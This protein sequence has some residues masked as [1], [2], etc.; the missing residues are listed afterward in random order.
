MTAAAIAII[1]AIAVYFLAMLLLP[2]RFFAD[3]G[4]YLQAS[5]DRLAR[6]Q[7]HVMHK[8]AGEN[9]SEAEKTLRNPLVRAYLLLPGARSTLPAL[10]RANLSDKIDKFVMYGVV[11]LIGLFFLTS[12][13]GMVG[14]G[15][16]LFGTVFLMAMFVQIKIN[17]RR[18]LFLDS[19]PDALDMIIRSVRSGYPLNTALNMVAENMAP[20]VSTEFKRIVDEMTYGWTLSEALMRFAERIDE[21]DIRFFVVVLAVQQ[22]SGG[23]LSEVL[24]NLS[25]VLRQRKHLRLKIRALS[26]EGRATAWILGSLPLFVAIVLHFMEPQ[27]LVPLIETQSGHYVLA[28]IVGLITSGMLIVRKMINIDI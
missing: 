20:P 8:S 14:V 13:L 10:A 26:S 3:E 2:K 25:R 7:T 22:E 5:L 19:F 15:L 12:K 27:H 6:E 9:F 18:N 11:L 21:P 23:N 4:R 16:S 24:G 17:K 28:G 1:I